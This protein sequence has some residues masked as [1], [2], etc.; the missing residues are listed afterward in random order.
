MGNETVR[1]SRYALS[2][3]SGALLMREAAIAAPL[4]LRERD[5]SDRDLDLLTPTALIEVARR[6][7]RPEQVEI[8]EDG[9]AGV[10]GGEVIP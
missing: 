5:W 4:Y 2:F 8:N 6:N 7:L 1:A 10:A 3:T 9:G